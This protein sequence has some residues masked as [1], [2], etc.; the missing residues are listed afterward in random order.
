MA[1]YCQPREHSGVRS[2]RK[3]VGQSACRSRCASSFRFEVIER[4]HK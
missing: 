4:A 1:S 3:P 2:M